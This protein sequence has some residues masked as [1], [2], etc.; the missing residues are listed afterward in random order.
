MN[1]LSSAWIKFFSRI[2]HDLTFT[3]AISQWIHRLFCEYTMS[4]LYVSRNHYNFYFT[5]PI[6]FW[7]HYRF[8]EFTMNSLSVSRI[9]NEF[10]FISRINCGFT[11]Y[12]ANLF[13]IYFACY[14]EFTICLANLLWIHYLFRE[15]TLNSLSFSRIHCELTFTFAISLWIH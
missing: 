1:L 4:L 10:L 9:E 5:I 6:S 11:S 3:F 7:I 2:H 13:A 15:S 12:F 8:R 14:F